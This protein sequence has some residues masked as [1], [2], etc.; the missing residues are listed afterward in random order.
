LVLLRLAL[1]RLQL[2]SREI[3]QLRLDDV[4]VEKL[5]Y[6]RRKAGGVSGSLSVQTIGSSRFTALAEEHSHFTPT[7]LHCYLIPYYFY[8]LSQLS[9]LHL[10]LIVRITTSIEGLHWALP[11]FGIGDTTGQAA[12]ETTSKQRH[13]SRADLSQ[14]SLNCMT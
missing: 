3:I 11:S 5:L 12:S 1:V 4:D 7:S 8:T 2:L 14:S 10:Q 9:R 6:A 13:S